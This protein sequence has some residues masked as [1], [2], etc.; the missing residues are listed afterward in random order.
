MK[1]SMTEMV[2]ALSVVDACLRAVI[3]YTP[4]FWALENPSGSLVKYLGTPVYVFHPWHFEGTARKRTGLWGNFN[5]PIRQ[6]F[7]RPEVTKS[8]GNIGRSGDYRRA[9]TPRGFAEAF[10]EANR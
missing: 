7:S 5:P 6:V 10:F 3:I 4:K 1:K 9:V 2:D 8:T